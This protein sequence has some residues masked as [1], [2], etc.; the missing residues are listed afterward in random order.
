MRATMNKYKN[1]T[2]EEFGRRV[3]L[4][5]VAENRGYKYDPKRGLTDLQTGHFVTNNPG[6]MAKNLLGQMTTERDL[7]TFESIL[8]ILNKLYIYE[9][10]VEKARPLLAE[11]QLDLPEVQKIESF[12]TG[13]V[14]WFRK[15][16]EICK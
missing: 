6:V 11:H 8:K 7:E 16:S 3:L 15:M 1:E 13:T 14:D 5:L 12:Q 4:T 10:I 2:A 9:K